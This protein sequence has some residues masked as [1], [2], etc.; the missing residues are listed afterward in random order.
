MTSRLVLLAAAWIA[1][2]GA[3]PLPPVPPPPDLTGLIAW[4]AA[5]LDK[6]PVE[7]PRVPWPRPPLTLGP[8]APA[9]LVIPDAPKPR[10]PLPA[11]RPLPW[12][13]A[14][15]W[16]GIPS[17]A[18][19]CGRARLLKGELEEAARAFAQAARGTSDREVAHEAR[20]WHGEALWQ[21]GRVELA[22]WSFRQVTLDPQ[23]SEW[24]PWALHS[25]GWTALRLGDAPRAERAFRRLLDEPHPAPLETWGRHGLGLALYA[26][27]RWEDADRV[28]T[29]LGRHR[30]PPALERELLFWRGETLA[31]LGR[32]DAAID[33]L[34]AFVR[35]GEHALLE[36]ARVRLGW[37]QLAAGR[38]AEA[39]ASFRAALG[40]PSVAAGDGPRERDWAEAGL[41]LALGASDDMRAARAAL[42]AL[43]GRRAT[44]ALPVR[45]EL[46]AVALERG[47]AAEAEALAQEVL[48]GTPPA[49]VRAWALLVLG[50]AHRLRRNRD[51]ARTQF[52]LARL[53]DPGSPTALHA[54]LRL[55]QTNF[56]LREFAQAAAD[57]PPDPARSAPGPLRTALLIVAAEAAYQTGDFARAEG[58]YQRALGELPAG[59][60]GA[61]VR[62]ALAWTA[63][64]QGRRADAL[65][66]LVE[67]AR[68]APADPRIPDA[69]VLAS[70]LRLEAGDLS[71]ARELLERI[72]A[73]YGHHPRAEFARLNRALLLARTGPLDLAERELA[74]W[75]ERAPFPPLL[76]RAWAALG[77]VRLRSGR[78]AE[79]ATA[80]TRAAAE[81]A[82]PL[83]HLGLGTVALL[84]ERWE[85]AARELAR[86]REQGTPAVAAAAEYGLGVV[87]YHQGRQAE[88]RSAALSML[89]RAPDSPE[90]ARL[91]YVLVTLAVADRD[92]TGA[93]GWARRLVTQ[94]PHDP[95]ADD[96]LERVGAA[97]AAAGVWPVA[98]EA[99]ALL[100]QEYPRSPFVETSQLAWGQALLETG[101]GAEARR[102]LEQVM[103][104]PGSPSGPRGWVALARAREATGDRAAALEAYGRA[105]AVGLSP[106]SDRGVY[107]AYARMLAA[108]RR[109]DEARTVL[110]ALL[111]RAEGV[112]AADVALGLAEAW[113]AR[114]DPMA[115]AEFYM[116]A[117]YL[118]PESPAGR[119]GLLG[120]GQSFKTARDPAAA[121]VVLE[122]L[123]AQ[124]DLA[125]ELAG[126]ARELLS[127][128]KR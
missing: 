16:L 64:R 7:P 73:D 32:W 109:W 24:T 75:I 17:E 116:T 49:P 13:C 19:E 103:A 94:F 46:A 52:E 1:L 74:G 40:A 41:A 87:A 54:A 48:A 20:Y 28:W 80:F 45:L 30:V 23:R 10:A 37:A 120:A 84:Q 92:W 58:A 22:D 21:L 18:L 111:A 91:L 38:A 56:E 126:P 102:V 34:G 51:E 68:L 53:T 66:R 33:H 89:Q 96:A 57:V 127:Q 8:V 11:A 112:E 86:A 117:A 78:T 115:A 77:A 98:Y 76:G 47:H 114:G 82:G 83:A 31:R 6:P 100:R 107:L 72:V 81:G 90:A 29:E 95:A 63:L 2:T 35:T 43:D 105:L 44:L 26:L 99:Y 79:A 14:M 128:V 25:S 69:L 101:R 118:A 36:V 104:V 106:E 125:P 108:E 113:A 88:F 61:A 93:L 85:E 62:L 97:A 59:P 55:A 121:R 39:A 5:P 15:A 42:A 65:Q 119:R 60:E 124:P 70:E 3:A 110:E 122:R 9:P 50:E 71:G 27:G 67:V 12:A 4:A 123:L